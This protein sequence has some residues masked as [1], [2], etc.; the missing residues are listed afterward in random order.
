MPTS[1]LLFQ[2]VNTMNVQLSLDIAE[3]VLID[4][5]QQCNVLS[6]CSLGSNWIVASIIVQK[7]NKL[8]D[9]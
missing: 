4:I 1:A 3:K 8:C 7:N 5:K 2:L 6:I 9:C